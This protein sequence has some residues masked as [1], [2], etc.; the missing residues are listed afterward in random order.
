[1]TEPTLTPIEQSVAATGR[2][3]FTVEP[4]VYDQMAAGVDQLRGY[5]WG[6]GTKAV[7]LHGL[8]LREQLPIAND[9]S[10]F[11]LVNLE[12]WRFTDADEEMMQPAIDAGLIVEITHSEWLSLKPAEDV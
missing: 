10:G 8:P 4:N 9:D 12:K 3:C 7:T 11:V 2:R 1:M 6:E 5:P